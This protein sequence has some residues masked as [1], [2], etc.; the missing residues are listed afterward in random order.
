MKMNVNMKNIMNLSNNLNLENFSL[1][2]NQEVLR[3]L[4]PQVNQEVLKNLVPQVNQEVLK[5]LVPQINQEVLKNFSPEKIL[6]V[7]TS[8]FGSNIN[9]SFSKII[10][11]LFFILS[12]IILFMNIIQ[13]LNPIHSLPP[14][15]IIARGDND[16]TLDSIIKKLIGQKNINDQA[17][18]NNQI[19]C[20]YDGFAI[21]S[22]Y[23]LTD[24]QRNKFEE[25]V[26]N[27]FINNGKYKLTT[28][29]DRG[30]N[31]VV[32]I[33][34]VED[35]GRVATSNQELIYMVVIAKQDTNRRF[36][37]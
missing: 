12:F 33:I 14:G 24:R 4:S 34:N 35:G 31:P 30:N 6:E 25:I 22:Y 32:R 8:S 15:M 27:S 11:C 9:F 1:E 29:M 2:V 7:F 18:Q 37:A 16:E 23:R 26:K 10:V 5:N 19:L 36:S 17:R 3:N 21:S 20:S 13:L 28:V